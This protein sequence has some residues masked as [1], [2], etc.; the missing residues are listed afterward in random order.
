MTTFR[1]MTFPWTVAVRNKPFVF[2]TIVLSSTMLSLV[3]VLSIP[4]PKLLSWAEYPFP[5]VRFARSRLRLTPPN[6]HMPPQGLAPFPFRTA[7]F[8]LISWPEPPP[9]KMPEAQLVE[10]VTPVTVRPLPLP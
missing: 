5:L 3:P 9:T 1:R 8:P 7:V 10:T 6:T 4:I 2:P